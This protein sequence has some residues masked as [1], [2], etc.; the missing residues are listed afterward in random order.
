MKSAQLMIGE[1][2]GDYELGVYSVAVRLAELWYFMPTILVS[3]FQDVIQSEEVKRR[4]LLIL[5]Y[6][7]I[8]FAVLAVI[9]SIINVANIPLLAR[10]DQMISYRFTDAYKTFKV[11]GLSLFGQKIDFTELNTYVRLDG[12][13]NYYMNCMWIYLLS[14]DGIIFSIAFVYVYF[15]SMYRL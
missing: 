5:F 9:L 14:N 10:I 3:V 4:G 1:M 11:Y 7:S 2:L 13:R 12:E 8:V 15:S 6:M